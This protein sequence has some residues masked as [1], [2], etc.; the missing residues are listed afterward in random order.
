MFEEMPLGIQPSSQRRAAL[1]AFV[2]HVT[3]VFVAVYGTRGS[4]QPLSRPIVD[5]VP[6]EL[7]RA[8]TPQT[9][10]NVAPREQSPLVPGAPAVP[11]LRLESPHAAAPKLDSSKLD[12]VLE[13]IRSMTTDHPVAIVRRVTRQWLVRAKSIAFRN[14]SE[15]S[16]LAIQ[17]SSEGQ[18]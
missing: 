5:T 2:L 4:G 15:I 1:A 16:R 6:I 7:P 8:S 12:Q 9:V 11:R 17:T 3:I 18:D 13:A 14:S 10:P